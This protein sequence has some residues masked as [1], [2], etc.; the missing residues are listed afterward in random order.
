MTKSLSEKLSA[1][2]VALSGRK[3]KAG[4]KL[5]YSFT[6]ESGVEFEP[7]SRKADGWDDEGW[8][9]YAGSLRKEVESMLSVAG[10]TCVEVD[11][12]EKGHVYVQL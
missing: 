6:D 12:G 3:T 4:G 2:K 11:I 10:I 5:K 7:A 8:E 1:V 9:T